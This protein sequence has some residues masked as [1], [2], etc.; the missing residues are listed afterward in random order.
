MNKES[1]KYY[2]NLKLFLPIHGKNEKQ[3]FRNILLRLTEL[4]N[5]DPSVTYEEICNELG[6]PYEIVTDYFDNAEPNYLAKKIRTTQYLRNTF[7]AC[8]IILLMLV[9]IRSFFLQKALET[10][11][12]EV[13]IY[14]QET[15]D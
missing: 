12:S 13:I 8:I 5:N 1:R 14:E 6:S 7:I 11:Q 9:C 10:V 3:L 2:N 4:N 15:I